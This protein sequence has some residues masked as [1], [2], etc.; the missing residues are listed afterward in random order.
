M[1]LKTDRIERSKSLMTENSDLKQT[2]NFEDEDI[3]IAFSVL[4]V[5]NLRIQSNRYDSLSILIFCLDLMKNVN[6]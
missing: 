3:R 5:G 2:V 4:D 1:L 6:L